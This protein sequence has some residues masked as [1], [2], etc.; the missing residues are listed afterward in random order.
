MRLVQAFSST[1][2]G[3]YP[4]LAP[5]VVDTDCRCL[6]EA[7]GSRQVWTTAAQEPNNVTSLYLVCNVRQYALVFLTATF[8]VP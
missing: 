7:I 2:V 3:L 1:I 6:E 4:K 8:G 5:P